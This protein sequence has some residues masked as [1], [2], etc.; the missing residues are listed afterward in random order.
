MV[1]DAAAMAVV[2]AARPAFRGAHDGV[3]FAANA[4]FLAAGYS[5]C[6]VGPAALTDPPPSGEE[7]VGIDGWNSM[8]NCYAFLYIKEERGKKKRVLVKCLVIG[9]V[10]AIDVLDLESQNK[11]PYNIQI[12]VKDFFSEEQPKN[13]GNMYKNFAGLI[14]TM[15]SNALSKL[16][17]KDAGAAK[18]P[19]VETSSSIHRSENP[20]LRTT[21]PGLVYPPIAP[22]GHD[23]AF[24]GPGA[25]FYPH[26]GIGGGGS[27]HVGP[28]DPRFFPSNPFPVP[29][30]GPGSV[31]PGGRYDPIGPPDVPGFE[32]SRFVRR[33]RPPAGTT[34]PD[35][36]FFQPGPHGPF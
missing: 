35:L 20:G 14:E 16:D 32:P 30:G 19:E 8:D 2:K 28:N 13:Y 6:A 12:N 36:E 18:N 34:H 24:P 31:P 7:E 5:L 25:G 23:D 27:M 3:A 22:L 29:F 15:N 17:E 21:E 11:G 26:S 9:D 10:L 4:A 1:T 33:P